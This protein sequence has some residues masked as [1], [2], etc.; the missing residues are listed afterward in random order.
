MVGKDDTAV[1]KDATALGPRGLQRRVRGGGVRQRQAVVL[2]KY[3]AAGAADLAQPRKIQ[4]PDVC[5][6]VGWLPKKWGRRAVNDA[7]R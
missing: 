7:H 3:N 5:V 6:E 1:A 4:I 2:V